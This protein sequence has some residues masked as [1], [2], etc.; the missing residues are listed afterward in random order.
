MAGE[1][2]CVT[3]AS[4]YIGSHCVRE[5]LERGY[6][7]R[8]TVRSPSDEAKTGHLRRLGDVELVAADLSLP[9]SFDSAVADCEFVLH[10][11]SVVV[12]SA[13]DGQ[14]EIVDPSVN[15][16][17]NVIDACA[18]S[19]SV[20]RVVQTSS[21]AAI[22][23]SE[24]PISHRFTEADW[25]ESATVKDLPYDVSKRQ[26]ERV[27][28][29]MVD[30]LPDGQRF[31]LTAINPSF[32]LG[33]VMNRVHLRTSPSMIRTLLRRQYPATPNLALGIVDVREVATAHVNALEAERI[34]PRYICHHETWSMPEIADA[35][36][37]AYPKVPKHRMPNWLMYLI[38]PMDSRLNWGFLRRNLG[39]RRQMSND[40]IKRELGVNFRPVHQTLH[41]CA[42]SLVEQGFI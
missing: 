37:A 13:K 23:D 15:G 2:V 9:G 11:A 38:S 16:T 33:P 12:L 21:V 30:E 28:R 41:D 4:G 42:Q 34:S 5:L 6:R 1:R 39:K 20:R 7:V 18:K 27:A 8:G 25:N 32:V 35:L 14:R 40:L 22:L 36:R 3:G 17:R 31:E 26:A 10:T 24:I 29:S 19:S